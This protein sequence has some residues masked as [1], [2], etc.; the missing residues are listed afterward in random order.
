MFAEKA[1]LKKQIPATGLTGISFEGN[2]PAHNCN[3]KT[4]TPKLT[5]EKN[6]WF[7]LSKENLLHFQLEKQSTN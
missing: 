4:A 1:E 7:L 5:E 6:K 3:L 2:L